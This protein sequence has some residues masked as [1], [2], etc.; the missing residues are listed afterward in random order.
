MKEPID[1]P[2]LKTSIVKTKQIESRFGDLRWINLKKVQ[3]IPSSRE[4]IIKRVL[5]NPEVISIYEQEG[6]KGYEKGYRICQSVFANYEIYRIKTL[7]YMLHKLFKRIF[8]RI[9]LDEQ[10]LADI[11]KLESTGP[12]IVLANN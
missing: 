10:L 1:P 4:K 6:F 9:V 8:D 3:Y 5:G 2:F 7:A 11:R 12:V